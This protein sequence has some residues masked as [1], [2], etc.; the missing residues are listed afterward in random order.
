MNPLKRTPRSFKA[1]DSEYLPSVK[2]ASKYG[3]T[4]AYIIR[5]FLKTHAEAKT[6]KFTVEL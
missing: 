1:F 2:K 5:K 6:N 3:Q 4:I